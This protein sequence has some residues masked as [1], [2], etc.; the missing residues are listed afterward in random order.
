MSLGDRLRRAGAALGGRA[1]PDGSAE[2]HVGDPRFDDWDIV[3]EFEDLDGARALRQRL[4]ELGQ[5]AVMTS[6]WPLDRFGRG[7]LAIRVP[8]GQWTDAEELLSEPED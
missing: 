7:D 6:D 2:L 3:E 5:E 8:P 1:H 4:E